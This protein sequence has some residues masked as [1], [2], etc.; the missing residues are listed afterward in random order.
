[1]ERIRVKVSSLSFEGG[2]TISVSAGCAQW[3]TGES[4][5]TLLKRAD[6]AL[7]MAKEGGRNRIEYSK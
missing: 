6:I 3:K 7:Y 5:D 2:F 1:M 4:V